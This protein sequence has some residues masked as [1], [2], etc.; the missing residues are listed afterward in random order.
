MPGDA[1]DNND[2][3][4]FGG[5]WTLLKLA[6]LKKYLSAFTLALSKQNFRLVYV[7]AFA[8]TG[9]CDVKVDGGTTCVDG[10]A[11]IALL[12][13]NRGTLTV[14]P[15]NKSRELSVNFAIASNNGCSK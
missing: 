5:A 15:H 13:Q 6:V 2:R 12:G 14:I 10:S 9:R 3:H 11:R 7:D 4:S 1:N 8:G